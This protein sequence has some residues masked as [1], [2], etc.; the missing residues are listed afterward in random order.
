MYFNLW[1]FILLLYH[2]KTVHWRTLVYS[3]CIFIEVLNIITKPSMLDFRF[4]SVRIKEIAL[5]D[6]IKISLGYVHVILA[7]LEHNQW[8]LSH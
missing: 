8:S 2:V 3:T 6:V 7:S 5:Y 4:L 1:S